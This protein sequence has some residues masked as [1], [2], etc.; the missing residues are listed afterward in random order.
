M[1]DTYVDKLN[2]SYIITLYANY[3]E[4]TKLYDDRTNWGLSACLR[5]RYSSDCPYCKYDPYDKSSCIK[6]KWSGSDI[7]D[8]VLK[9]KPN[10]TESE[11]NFNNFK[12]GSVRSTE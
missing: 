10:N 6:F 4:D 9:R 3:D 5:C 7:I 12:Y 1:N 8:L 2:T 11:L